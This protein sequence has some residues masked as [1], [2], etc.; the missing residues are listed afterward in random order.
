MAESF[1][2]EASNAIRS[3]FPYLIHD[4]IDLL[5]SIESTALNSVGAVRRACDEISRSMWK[6][7]MQT[8]VVGSKANALG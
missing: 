1:P 4:A 6:L 8:E 3:R 7:K 5:R 2:A